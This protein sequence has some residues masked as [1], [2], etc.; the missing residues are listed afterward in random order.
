D[1]WETWGSILS[2][3]GSLVACW[4]TAR[5]GGIRQHTLLA[6]DARTGERVGEL[7]DGRESD[8]V[9]VAFSPTAGDGRVLARTTRFGFVRPVLWDARTGERPGLAVAADLDVPPIGWSPDARAVLLCETGGVQR[10]HRFDL[11]TGADR[12]LDHPPGTYF[13]EIEG[14]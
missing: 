1:S 9:G 6:L 8:V 13:D 12:V 3:D 2:A 7:D 11:D 5:A 10:L 14:G 4:S